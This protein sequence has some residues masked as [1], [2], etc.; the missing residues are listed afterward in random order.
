MHISET[1]LVP[2]SG[3]IGMLL[4]STEDDQANARLEVAPD[5]YNEHG[6]SVRVVATQDIECGASVI[7]YWKDHWGIMESLFQE[8]LVLCVLH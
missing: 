7:L 1:A 5:P 8:N 3:S 6:Y 4:R 2:L